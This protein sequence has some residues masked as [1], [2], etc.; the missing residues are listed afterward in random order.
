MLEQ[1]LSRTPL[2]VAILFPSLVILGLMQMRTRTMTIQRLAILPI[3][4]LLLS[5]FG[6]W[7]SF[8]ASPLS[9]LAWI[10]GV[11]LVLS[12]IQFL[13]RATGV[14]FSSDTQMYTVP[15]SWVPLILILIIFTARYMLAVLLAMNVELRTAIP[16]TIG[17]SLV[18]GFL[19]GS[20]M[21]RALRI[22]KISKITQTLPHVVLDKS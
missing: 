5:F 12:S 14:R 13:P 4:M 17:A 10:C 22:W 7:S 1:I 15:G 20:F 11:I 19:S 18:L 9:I 6:I 3:A 2:W 21:A 16:F 8:G